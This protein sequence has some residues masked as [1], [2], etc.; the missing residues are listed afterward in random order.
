VLRLVR[1]WYR[2]PN[3]LRAPFQATAALAYGHALGKPDPDLALRSL[4]GLAAMH[5]DPRIRAAVGL[6]LAGL[7]AEDPTLTRR[8]MG[9]L[10]GWLTDRE[11]RATGEL[12]F[13]ILA[14]TLIEDPELDGS[15][16]RVEAWP[17]LL[18]L[19]DRD[20]Q[21]RGGLATLWR[22]VLN[23]SE[24]AKHAIECLA[25]WAHDL[26]PDPRGCVLLGQLAR[27][28]SDGHKRTYELFLR[29]AALWTSPRNLD[30]T[31]RTAQAVRRALCPLEAAP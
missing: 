27:A 4:N 7:L 13:L 11:R 14:S 5:H 29:L 23:G 1:G 26:E 20:P 8:I 15:R 21:L 9:L 3:P 19:A 12:A 17:A 2:D 31:P 16:P 18:S 22:L 25:D 6:G 24:Y 28:A 30:P 10:L